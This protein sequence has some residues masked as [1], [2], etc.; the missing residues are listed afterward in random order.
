MNTQESRPTR[1][2]SNPITM[3]FSSMKSKISSM[4]QVGIQVVESK[5]YTIRRHLICLV[6]RDN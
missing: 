5:V 4:S 2:Y 1:P 6:L 3:S